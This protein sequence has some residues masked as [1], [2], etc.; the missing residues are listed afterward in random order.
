MSLTF[1][2]FF[3]NGRALSIARAVCTETG[4][5][6]SDSV[7][8]HPEP[9]SKQSTGLAKPHLGVVLGSDS[10]DTLLLYAKEVKWHYH[11]LVTLCN[12]Y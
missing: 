9:V 3:A 6:Q 10:G 12:C 1:L 7:C 2:S 4:L 8:K 11:H 5:T